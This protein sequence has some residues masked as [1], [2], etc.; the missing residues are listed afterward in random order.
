MYIPGEVT[1]N[2]LSAAS[3]PLQELTSSC[4][5]NQAAKRVNFCHRLSCYFETHQS[6]LHLLQQRL[7]SD[8]LAMDVVRYCFH[9]D[10]SSVSLNLA[11]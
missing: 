7:M 6:P 4:T 8:Q 9:G 11:S 2:A 3:G 5:T 10:L 1:C